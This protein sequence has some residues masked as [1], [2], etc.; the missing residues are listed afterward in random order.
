M[1]QEPWIENDRGHRI[2]KASRIWESNVW[3]ATVG[4]IGAG[5]VMLVIAIILIFDSAGPAGRMDG[6]VLAITIIAT[7]L[8]L[9]PGNLI[10]VIPVAV[11]L[12]S[13]KGLRIVAPLKNLYIPIEE[14]QEI[15]D[16]ISA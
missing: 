9:F 6:F 16:S 2:F 10:A 3:G 7:L 4:G 8:A 13:G 14:V 12:Q 1:A 5:L 11:E 15:R